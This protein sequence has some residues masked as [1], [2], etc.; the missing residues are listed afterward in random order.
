[1]SK[2]F[3][4][5]KTCSLNSLPMSTGSYSSSTDVY[6][7]SYHSSNDVVEAINR[8][9]CKSYYNSVYSIA[10][11]TLQESNYGYHSFGN[12]VSFD[13]NV[14][15]TITLPTYTPSSLETRVCS[16]ILQLNIS[17]TSG[18]DPFSIILGN[19][20][21]ECLVVSTSPNQPEYIELNTNVVRFAEYGIVGFNKSVNMKTLSVD[22]FYPAESFLSFSNAGSGGAWYLSIVNTSNSTNATRLIGTLTYSLEVIELANVPSQPPVFGINNSKVIQ[23][24]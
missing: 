22:T 13:T 2:I 6:P 24:H 21:N 11:Y 19:S 4:V 5:L 15:S 9:L 14:S 7:Y 18:N 8:T 20:N 10:R 1:M 3:K 17:L 23:I 12:S 16:V